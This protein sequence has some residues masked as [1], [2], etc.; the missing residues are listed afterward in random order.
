MKRKASAGKNDGGFILISTAVSQEH[1]GGFLGPMGFPFPS[2]PRVQV[3][4]L[5][6]HKISLSF[7]VSGSE[8]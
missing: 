6:G 2:M 3:L 8:G 7:I 1:V 4:E 5:S